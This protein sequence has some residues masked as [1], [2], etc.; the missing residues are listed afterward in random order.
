MHYKYSYYYYQVKTLIKKLIHKTKIILIV[1]YNKQQNLD[2]F[3]GYTNHF[4]EK[5]LIFFMI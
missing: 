4:L 3:V 2:E 1:N 5:N